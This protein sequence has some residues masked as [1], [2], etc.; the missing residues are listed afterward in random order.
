M[1]FCLRSASRAFLFC[2]LLTC[3]THAHNVELFVEDNGNGTIYIETGVSTGGPAAG[4]KIIVRDKATTQPLSMFAMPDSGKIN[5]PMPAVPYTITLDMGTGHVETKTGP[6]KDGDEKRGL[7]GPDASDHAGA[8]KSR[9]S[10]MVLGA[11][12]GS[13]FVITSVLLLVSFLFNRKNKAFLKRK[14]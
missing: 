6:F 14:A 3:G 11:A 12:V 5:I 13:L 10:R 2:T 8:H 7:S 1:S 9:S 4:A